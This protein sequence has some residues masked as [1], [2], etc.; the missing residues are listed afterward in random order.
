NVE[1]RFAEH[2]AGKGA[3]YLRGKGPLNL[4]YQ[5]KV[6]TRSEALKAEIAIK[7][8]PKSDKEKIIGK[9]G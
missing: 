5:K 3:K 4:V 2:Q 9:A 6:G 8:M 7:N 1:R